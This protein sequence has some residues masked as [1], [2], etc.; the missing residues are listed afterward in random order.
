MQLFFG[1]VG[2]YNVLLCWPVIILFHL[3]GV[4]TFGLPETTSQAAL[5]G[6]NV[7][8]LFLPTPPQ[9]LS[10]NSCSIDDY[11]SDERLYLRARDAEDD[12][13]GRDDWSEP[14][15]PLGSVWGRAVR[16]SG[17]NAGFIRRGVGVFQLCGGRGA[18]RRRGRA[19]LSGMNDEGGLSVVC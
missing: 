2:L 11:H 5:V 6:I 8:L 12:A 1:F 13:S 4:E 15:H 17:R 19:R 14:H 9:V 10:A 18:W 16:S 7:S 3:M